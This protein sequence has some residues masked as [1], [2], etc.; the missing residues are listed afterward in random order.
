MGFLRC[1]LADPAFSCEPAAHPAFQQDRFSGSNDFM[2]THYLQ[3]VPV[4]IKHEGCV[5]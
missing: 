2:V 4:R 5:V 1:H 3:V